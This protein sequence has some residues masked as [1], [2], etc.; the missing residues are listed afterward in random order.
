V[1][2]SVDGHDLRAWIAAREGEITQLLCDMIAVDSVTGNEGPMAELCAD[3]LSGHGIEAIL[4]PAKDRN[5]A[6]GTIGQGTRALVLS[7][8]LDTVPPDEGDWTHGPFNPVV[9]GGRVFGLGASDLHASIVGA[10]FAQ[11]FLLEAGC[12]LSGRL[13]SAFTIEEETTGDG[14]RLFLDWAGKEGFLDF[15]ET[16]CVV[17]EPTGLEHVC[18]G[19]RASSFLVVEVEGQGGHGSRPHLARNPLWK[20]HGILAG[21]RDLEED[22]KR[23]YHDADFG[24]TTLTPTSIEGGSLERTNVIPER[25]RAVIDCRPTPGL[26]A[27]D[28]ALFRSE[29]ATFFAAQAEDGYDITTRELYAREGHILAAGHPLAEDVVAVLREDLAIDGAATRVNPAGN[30][31]VFFALH[32][33]PT[34]NKVGPGH[35]EQAHRI[36][37]FVTVENLLRGVELYARIALRRLGA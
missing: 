21:L 15:T 32:G 23:R 19:N 31:A 27:D 25:A 14:T 11:R 16:E 30:D 9:Q 28:L 36:N 34:I 8:H 3:W 12:E 10:Y 29:L 24:S 4:Q 33:V 22:W 20:L 18:L 35:P 37:E 6:L 13:V 2:G 1:T 5:N 17:T 26:W 7:G